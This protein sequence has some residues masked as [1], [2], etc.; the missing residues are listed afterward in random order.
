MEN[1]TI[2]V[3][4]S[5]I[6]PLVGCF[7][8]FEAIS[9]SDH[10][11][12]EILAHKSIGDKN[13]SFSFMLQDKYKGTFSITIYKPRYPREEILG[14]FVIQKA[15]NFTVN[16][17]IFS[18]DGQCM[19]TLVLSNGYM[20][21][22]KIPVQKP[23]RQESKPMASSMT[24]AE[25]SALEF[26]GAFPT[27]RCAV[28]DPEFPSLEPGDKTRFKGVTYAELPELKWGWEW[29]GSISGILFVQNS[30]GSNKNKFRPLF[31]NSLAEIA[32]K[33]TDPRWKTLLLDQAGRM[34]GLSRVMKVTAEIIKVKKDPDFK[35]IF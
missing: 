34:E 20:V 32:D 10:N 23:L 17:K 6:L 11:I 16:E 21:V 29:V 25:R 35:D 5:S 9:P 12:A 1:I 28:S 30:R 18:E 19:G 33:L 13:F 22:E 2:H 27:E 3:V 8:K 7:L 31:L 15:E 24:N 26:A 4:S 14:I